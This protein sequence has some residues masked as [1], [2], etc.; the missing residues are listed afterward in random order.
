MT[1][2]RRV[3]LDQLV[4]EVRNTVDVSGLGSDTVFHYSI[5]VLD[6]SGDGRVEQVED[7]GSGKLLLQGG[8]I[9]ISKLNPRIS[10]VVVAKRHDEP[11]TA[12]T[13]FIALTP[14]PDIEQR[15]L[16]Y[17]LESETTRQF[18]NG[19]ASS[20]TKSQQRVRPE[21]LTKIWFDVPP[22]RQQLI[23]SDYLDTETTHIDALVSKRQRQLELLKEQFLAQ[24]Q[25][26]VTGG[27][28]FADPLDV[29]DA[30]IAVEG[31]TKLKLGANLK[32]GSGT[33]PPS[34]D[35]RYYG[36]GIPWV[37]TGNLRDTS[38]PQVSRSI[39]LEA[40]EK[41]SAL[42]IHPAGSLVVAMYGATIGRLGVTTYPAVVNQACCV[43]QAR[44]NVNAWFLFY[45][46]LA[47]RSA[48]IE[49]SVGAGQPN[50][51]QEILRS[52]RIPVPQ[53][54]TQKK[55][56]MELDALRARMDLIESRIKKQ[57]KVLN[58][59]RQALITAAVTGEL[60]IPGATA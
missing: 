39:T 11:T 24:V 40:L 4:N 2:W 44:A 55:I 28:T 18:L 27:M 10:R 41:F 36:N 35:Q 30:D 25:A 45:Y 42:E 29:R 26:R 59:R 51:S 54:Q 17:W 46:L 9:L 43:I 58:E 1:D 3:R 56:V 52:I 23:I 38:I 47:H 7:I 50:I 34:G 57:L 32:F 33:T 5:P 8:E 13:E 19:A 31:W 15:Y 48:L 20:V 60:D 49:R 12:S 16:C 37:V 21:T 6:D 22:M 53:M 14:G